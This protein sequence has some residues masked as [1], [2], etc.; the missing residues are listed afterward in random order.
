MGYQLGI[1]IG[2]ANTVVAISDG[3]WPQVLTV[4]GGPSIPTVLHFPPTG[5]LSFGRAAS[6]RALTDPARATEGFVRRVGDSSPIMISGGA[7]AP[8]GLV[9]RFLDRVIATAAETRGS[10]PDQVVVTFPTSWNARRRELFAEA[11]ERLDVRDIRVSAAPAAEALGAV[12]ARRAATRTPGRRT[13]LVAVY[14]FGA[15][16]CETAVLSVTDYGAEVVGSP[17]GLAHTGGVDLD[18]LLLEHVLSAAGQAA[19]E[20]DRSDPATVTALGR[21][22]HEIVAAKESLAADD[23]TSVPVT[24]PGVFAWVTLR[25]EEVERLVAPAVEDSVR[26]LVRTVRS[27]PASAESLSAVL[28]YGGVARMPLVD[29]LVRAA[30]PGAAR[31]EHR[32]AEDLAVGAALLAAG[33]AEQSE[34]VAGGATALIGPSTMEPPELSSF[35]GLS[36]PPAGTTYVAPGADAATAVG[37]GAGAG[38][39]P[40]STARLTAGY[41]AFP[42]AAA[43]TTAGAGATG[44]AASTAGQPDQQGLVSWGTGPGSGARTVVHGGPSGAGGAG[45]PPGGHAPQ[46]PGSRSAR[47]SGVLASLRTK[48]GIAAII[49]AVLFIAGGTALGLTL[50]SSDSSGPTITAQP[51]SQ[52]SS[53]PATAAAATP[54]VVTRNLVRVADSNEV[55][56]I[57]ERAFQEFR[58]SE[59]KVTVAFDPQVTDTTQAFTKLCNGDVAIAGT[60]YEL[61]PKFAPNPSCKDQVVGFEIAHHTLPIVVN[62]ANSWLGCMNLDQLKQIWGADS[63]VTRWNQIDPSYPD[64]PINFVG[65]KRD[66][67]QAQVF[68]A[69]ISGDS[70]KSRPYTTTDLAGVAQT[71]QNDRDAI[72]YLDFPT[73]NQLGSKLRGVLV[74]GGEGEGC[75]P[76]NA[77]TAGSGAYV[78]LCKPLFVYAR[79]DALKDPATVAYLRY[80]LEHAQTITTETGYVGRSNATTKSNIDRLGQLSQGVGPVTA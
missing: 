8:E 13:D 42:A 49:A 29:R 69:S 5:T 3:D 21:L 26:A 78:P 45:R 61:D 1:D 66:S 62:P 40:D 11:L 30:L 28:L 10:D 48:A 7:Y 19:A 75:Q 57:S 14:D 67:V 54:P 76:P 9:T 41:D 25:R 6:R 79:V 17:T 43:S 32:P 34:P 47:R 68:N 71:V 18:T 36:V 22:R 46:R 80:Y 12:L 37:V 38:W 53:Q 64:E 44:A 50:T 72:G 31:F 23:E 16:T 2:T 70:S 4:A 20:L 77:I 27:V 24:L 59:S 52:P 73:Y 55:A 56:P 35:P 60:S 39:D 51:P 15:G 63:K 33:L 58:Q 65:P 74:D